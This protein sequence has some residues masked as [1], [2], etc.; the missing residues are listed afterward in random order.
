MNTY[1][2]NLLA[3][4]DLRLINALQIH[5]RQ[6]W[7]V[8]GDVLGQ[9]PTSLAKRWNRLVE[10]G[11]AWISCHPIGDPNQMSLAFLDVQCEPRTRSRVVRELV[12]MTDVFSIEECSRARDLMLTVVTPYPTWMTESVYPQL[13]AV[14]G[15]TR[16]ETSF[17]TKLHRGAYDWRINAL[18]KREEAS[19]QRAAPGS[20]PARGPLP[21]HYAEIAALLNA[22][23]RATAADVAGATGLHPATARRQ[24]QRVLDSR[25]LAFRCEVAHR[26]AGFPVVCQWF[27]RLPATLHDDAARALARLGTLR[28]CAS[29]TGTANFMFMMWLRSAADVM[30]VESYVGRHL[31]ELDLVESAVITNIP[32]RVGWELDPHGFATGRTVGPGDVWSRLTP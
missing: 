18:S 28:I 3:E 12:A 17:C 32:K 7:T 16:Y 10:R 30:E 14:E 2:Q 13:D 21:S 26:A 22:N 8:L 4:E 24:L 9:H 31:P 6:T 25:T 23:G 5:P 27:G 15:I 1:L 19:L 11:L 20:P 29:I